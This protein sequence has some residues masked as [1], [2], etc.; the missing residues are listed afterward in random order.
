MLNTGESAAQPFPRREFQ[1]PECVIHVAWV[2][3]RIG[4]GDLVRL[5]PQG[6]AVSKPRALRVVE[7]IDGSGAGGHPRMMPRIRRREHLTSQTASRP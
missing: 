4:P 5:S 6:F 7:V 1:A 2:H 3:S